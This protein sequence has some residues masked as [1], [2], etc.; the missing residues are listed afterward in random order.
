MPL[1]HPLLF[2]SLCYID[3]H[4][5]HSE[6]GASV[7]VQNPAD[8]SVIGHVPMLAEKQISAGRHPPQR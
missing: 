7:A 2:K 6:D 4:W 5:V 1:D 8:Q 3:G